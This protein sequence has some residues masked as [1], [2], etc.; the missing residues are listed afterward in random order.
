VTDLERAL[1]CMRENREALLSTISRLDREEMERSRPGGWAV[2][3]VLEHVIE[4]EQAYA[5]VLAHLCGRTA[6]ELRVTAPRDAAD[7]GEMLAAARDAALAMVDG[8]V[9]EVLY[10][11]ARLGHEEYSALSVL[12]N[13]AAHDEDHRRQIVE[14]LGARAASRPVTAPTGTEIRAARAS[15]LPELTEIYNHY[16]VHTPATFDLE[17]YTVEGRRPWFEQFGASGRHR[18]LVSER[19]GAVTGYAASHQF[20]AKAAYDTTVE[21]TIYLH[22]DACGEGTGTALYSALFDAIAGEDLHMAVA[23]ITLPNAASVA[24]HERF[25]F[26]RVGVLRG[27]GRK[28]GQYWDV[29]WYEKPLTRPNA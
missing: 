28:F 15:D 20:R 16:V 12:E 27:V 29:A 14:L 1:E 18:L 26:T 10:K 17:R 4:S 8:I 21:T 23:G 9:D 11:L 2:G 24:L 19:E 25:G 5:R 22:A 7:A 13:I 3:R 6:P